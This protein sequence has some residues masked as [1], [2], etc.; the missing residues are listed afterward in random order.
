MVTTT[1]V[2]PDF[3]L[4]EEVLEALD[5]A[6]F[7]ITVAMWL[8]QLERSDRW[9]LV[10]ATPLYDRLGPLA[11]YRRFIDALS[12]KGPVSMVDL[13]IRLE[14]TRRPLIRALRK[15]FGNVSLAKGIHLESRS[16]G[17]T[18]IDDGY[19]YRIKP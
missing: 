14:S 12:T 5:K 4:G 3:A 1:Y 17:G 6:K 7:P 9:K 2:G 19:L 18:S 10:I 15:M 16:I 11:S 13:P 8:L